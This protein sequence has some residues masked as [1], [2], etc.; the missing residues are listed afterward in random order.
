LASSRLSGR[1]SASQACRESIAVLIGAL[2]VTA[3][4]AHGTINQSFPAVTVR[5]RLLGAKLAPRD[6]RGFRA[7]RSV[8]DL[9]TLVIA[10]LW[11]RGR[12]AT[13]CT[14]DRYT[15]A[16]CSAPSAR[17]CW[18]AAIGIGVGAV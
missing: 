2:L 12:G 6:R 1:S 15:L 8:A 13:A 3:E 16:P 9:A 11:F 14:S 7:R 18:Q 17:R 5:G 10:E 4:Y